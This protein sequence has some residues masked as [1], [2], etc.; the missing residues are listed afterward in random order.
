MYAREEPRSQSVAVLELR[1]QGTCGILFPQLKDLL[2]R[3][4][5]HLGDP[6]GQ[7]QGGQ[8]LPLFQ[9]YDGLPRAAYSIR[10]LL[11]RHFAVLEAKSAD[12]VA[13]LLTGH[14]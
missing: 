5:E 3:N 4:S 8:V 2:H 12:L 10:E 13:D 11:L 6:E 7:R 1:T 14:S 9:G